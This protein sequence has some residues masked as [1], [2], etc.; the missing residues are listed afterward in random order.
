[1]NHIDGWYHWIQDVLENNEKYPH[2]QKSFKHDDQYLQYK[3][4]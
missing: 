1:M 3:Q 4:T 2:K